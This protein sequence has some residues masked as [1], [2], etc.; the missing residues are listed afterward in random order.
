[1]YASFARGSSNCR[2]Q[3]KLR[4]RNCRKEAE[5]RYT[6]KVCNTQTL[7]VTIDAWGADLC[8]RAACL[9]KAQEDHEALGATL[10]K[11]DAHRWGKST[12]LKGMVKSNR[13]VAV[14]D[15]VKASTS[16]GSL[17]AQNALTGTSPYPIS[18]PMTPGDQELR[19]IAVGSEDI[20]PPG[21]APSNDD[22]FKYLSVVEKRA[23]RK[24]Q[25][26]A[27]LM[28]PA[29]AA[30]WLKRNGI[31]ENAE[32]KQSED[33]KKDEDAKQGE[34]ANKDQDV[35]KEN[36]LNCPDKQVLNSS[37]SGRS[38]SPFG[39]SQQVLDRTL[40]PVSNTKMPTV[41]ASGKL[42]AIEKEAPKGGS[43]V[44]WA[45]RGPDYLTTIGR[46]NDLLKQPGKIT[47]GR[48]AIW[49]FRDMQQRAGNLMRSRERIQKFDARQARIEA[50]E[51]RQKEER[52]MHE[53]HSRVSTDPG[54]LDRLKSGPI[55]SKGRRKS[56]AEKQVIELPFQVANWSSQ[57]PTSTAKS[58]E[59]TGGCWET[60]PMFIK[61]QWIVFELQDPDTVCG[62]AMKLPGS[63]HIGGN[64]HFCEVEYSEESAEG[65]WKFAAELVCLNK[66]DREMTVTFDF[67]SNANDFKVTLAKKYGSIENAWHGLLDESNDGILSYKEFL[68]SVQTLE[69]DDPQLVE[70]S[71]WAQNLDRLFEELDISGD[72]LLQLQDFLQEGSRRP[73]GRWWRLFI[74]DNWGATSHLSVVGPVVLYGQTDAVDI[75]KNFLEDMAGQR[76][77]ISFGLG[78]GEKE[79]TLNKITAFQESETL[80]E[81]QRWLRG[82]AREFGI[83]IPDV[84]E[85]FGVFSMYDTDK[86]GNIE[87]NE[88]KMLLCKLLE[89]ADVTD[90]PGDRMSMFWKQVDAS[91][92]GEVDFGE[93]LVWYR[94]NFLSGDGS[95]GSSKSKGQNILRYYYA[96]LA[97][98]RV[99]PVTATTIATWARMDKER[100]AEALLQQRWLTENMENESEMFVQRMPQTRHSFTGLT[101]SERRSSVNARSSVKRS[102][103]NLE[104]AKRTS[105]NLNAGLVTSALSS[106]QTEETEVE[107]SQTEAFRAGHRDSL[108]SVI[109]DM[110]DDPET[111]IVQEAEMSCGSGEGEESEESNEEAE[112]EA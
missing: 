59:K 43:A 42:P 32:S 55:D 60:A 44:V 98:K 14:E 28:Q 25:A 50:R 105:S 10:L 58:L 82:L 92:N 62:M 6:P 91:G 19:M 15:D 96:S 71:A 2:Q 102:S 54:A 75:T 74:K 9:S 94:S 73:S 1:M 106:E 86:S 5:Q 68:E 70:S 72:G 111:T 20:M 83:P 78:E 67:E 22:Q 56:K 84:E 40:T 61:N 3:H 35:G 80:S 17:L 93:F 87:F 4:N 65:P 34:N 26:I 11:N 16:R 85:I 27:R 52:E 53:A 103:L 81:E 30:E 45:A 13:M 29:Q 63:D 97:T 33:A 112:E 36:T 95:S 77:N 8:T 31:E 99:V 21:A 64:P 18:H 57:R 37:P 49:D 76:A 39:Q 47:K 107:A 46:I 104:G 38:L 100:E 24:A 7:D 109:T 48:Q 41:Q 90:I 12:D 66:R 51:N 101:C 23:Q 108:G 88:F 69:R 110:A 79:G 89:V